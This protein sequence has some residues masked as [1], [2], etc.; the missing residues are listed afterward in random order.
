MKFVYT[1][2]RKV[3]AW[4]G[5]DY[6]GAS[7]SLQMLERIFDAVH[8]YPDNFEWL[9]SIPE[10]CVDSTVDKDEFDPGL[11]NT[12]WEGILHLFRRPYWCRIWTF[13]E[14]ILA[15]NLW[16]MCGLER[17]GF[18]RNIAPLGV[19]RTAL[20]CTEI[21]EYSSG[22]DWLPDIVG[23]VISRIHFGKLLRI[24]M[25]RNLW[26]CPDE[27]LSIR[28][29][30]DVLVIQ[31]MELVATD[32]KDKVFGLLGL[33]ESKFIPD[34]SKTAINVFR[35]FAEY[36]ILQRRMEISIYADNNY[37][38]NRTLDIPSWVPNW[39]AISLATLG[40]NPV[41]PYQEYN[42]CR[43]GIEL[44]PMPQITSDFLCS[45]GILFD[46]IQTM[47]KESGAKFT[48]DF[49]FLPS[50]EGFLGQ[51]HDY[52]SGITKMQAMLFITMAG[53]TGTTGNT[54]LHTTSKSFCGIAAGFIYNLLVLCNK[55]KPAL[56][57][58]QDSS[59]LLGIL[60][61]KELNEDLESPKKFLDVFFRGPPMDKLLEVEK[62]LN[63]DTT[64]DVDLIER[65]LRL[66]F[67]FR[68]SYALGK[69]EKLRNRRIF[70]T[71]KGYIGLYVPDISKD[72]I[73]AILQ[74]CRVP[75]VL[76]KVDSHFTLIS[77]CYV[78][79]IIDGEA[80]IEGKDPFLEIKI[81]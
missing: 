47:E 23:L 29:D 50:I 25:L 26:S 78:P 4:L 46:Q 52:P 13:Q 5:P 35:D 30:L 58:A 2:A 60:G 80:V 55:E 1:M 66:G 51:S 61:L 36:Y 3:I 19:G 69:L 37:D 43:G 6:A 68:P 31:T 16:L 67:T 20:A 49:G 8:Q 44:A 32:P 45:L 71:K 64:N 9:R 17:I 10:L 38:G 34:Y 27:L 72:D 14:L 15:R 39:Q 63:I 65:I 56:N 76:R 7:A 73:I 48:M 77:A 62:K 11:I 22:L 28:M 53:T 70:Y 81:H 74:D 75:L 33:T 41:S 42:A 79:G 24:C 59:C 40:A 57:L 18:E 21:L 12:H 54:R